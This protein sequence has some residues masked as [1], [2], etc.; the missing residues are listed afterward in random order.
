MKSRLVALASCLTVIVSVPAFAQPVTVG[1]TGGTLGI[2]PEAS[3]RLNDNVAVRGN[4]TFLGVG[5]KFDSDDAKY[6]A[7]VKLKSV[8]VML[9]VFPFGG[10]FFVSGGARINK[11]KASVDAFFPAGSEIGDEETLVDTTV[12]GRAHVKDFAPQLTIGW[13]GTRN[14]S[15]SF[16]IEAGVLFQGKVKLDPLT[17][18]SGTVSLTDLEVERQSLQ[19]DVDDYK[20]YPIL[21]A[22]IA[23]TF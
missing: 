3:Y 9:D 16:G 14:S 4:A 2:G 10:S 7:S 12:Y 15:L 13:A 17:E 11:N 19:D 21:Q 18:T 23:Y 8:G 20:V 6:D 5:G 1:L 22:K